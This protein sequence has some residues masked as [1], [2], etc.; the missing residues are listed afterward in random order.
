M[1][2]LFDNKEKKIERIA[3]GI[4]KAAIMETGQGSGRAA[5]LRGLSKIHGLDP[6]GVRAAV[7]KVVL[8]LHLAATEEKKSFLLEC[9][10]AWVAEDQA[11]RSGIFA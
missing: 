7:G 10:R 8:T 5:I 1:F 9:C 4:M 3:K 11:A 6:T 2:G